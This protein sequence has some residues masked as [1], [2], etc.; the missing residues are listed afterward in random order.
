MPWFQEENGLVLIQ[1][2]SDHLQRMND[3]KD[4]RRRWRAITNKVNQAIMTEVEPVQVRLGMDVGATEEELEERLWQRQE[5][6]GSTSTRC[7]G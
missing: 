2:E 7:E 3:N 4:T 1:A 6:W 5:R